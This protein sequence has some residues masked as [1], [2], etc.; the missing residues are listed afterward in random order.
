MIVVRNKYSIID[1]QKIAASRNGECLS[2]ELNGV[3]SYLVWKCELGHIWE[4]TFHDIKKCWC[5]KCADIKHRKHSIEEMKNIARGRNGECLSDTFTSIN[6]KL[7]WK[8]ND[9]GNTWEALPKSILQ[10]QWCK[11]CS[12]SIKNAKLRGR[13]SKNEEMITIDY[14]RAISEKIG[15]KCLSSM[16]ERST[17]KLDFS[18]INGHAFRKSYNEFKRSMYKCPYCTQYAGESIAR[19]L[20]E[21]MLGVSFPKSRPDWL[22]G[23]KGKKLELDGYN[24]K[25][26]I[27][28]EYQG[29][30]HY[31][32]VE[33]FSKYNPFENDEIKKHLCKEMGVFLITISYEISFDELQSYI[34]NS[35][36]TLSINIDKTPIDYHLS[37]VITRESRLN[38]LRDIARQK[39]GECLSEVYINAHTPLQFR[40]KEGHVWNARYDHIIEGCWCPFCF[41]SKKN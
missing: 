31:Q 39:G 6:S 17:T 12:Y 4:A 11:P 35:L 21:K 18:C 40:C 26:R 7:R 34:I 38:P 20:L 36:S 41:K 33:Y 24:E 22:I 13:S 32:R 14:I 37:F 29:K 30:Q 1:A 28:F 19:Y 15:Y 23:L 2:T 5:R 10:G 16:Y 9:C 27:A 8:C 25:L 3:T